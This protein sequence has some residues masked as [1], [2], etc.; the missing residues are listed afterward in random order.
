MEQE[1]EPTEIQ[2]YEKW[3]KPFVDG[4]NI[5]NREVRGCCKNRASRHRQAERQAESNYS[6]NIIIWCIVL[7][8]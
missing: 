8:K 7:S 1:E 4:L 3:E 6:T 2:Y 5:D